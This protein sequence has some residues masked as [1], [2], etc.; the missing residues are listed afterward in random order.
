MSKQEDSVP[1]RH[2]LER[3]REAV[4]MVTGRSRADLDSDRILQLALTQ[5]V[6]FVGEA[7]DRVSKEGQMRYPEVPWHDA[8]AARN[9][10][11]HGYHSVDY[12]I[13]WRTV[14]E[15]FPLLIGSLERALLAHNG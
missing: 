6:K 1:M 2:M 13:V 10:V 14:T 3:A 15:Q 9:R 5:L 4:A 12:N 11:I 7:A 8:I